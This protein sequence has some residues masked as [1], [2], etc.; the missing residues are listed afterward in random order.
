MAARSESQPN[1][2]PILL[3]NINKPLNNR[4]IPIKLTKSRVVV[5]LTG[6]SGIA[7]NPINKE[8]SK[9]GIKNKKMACQDRED[10]KIPPYVGPMAGAIEVVNV[11]TPIIVPRFS[12]GVK[13]KII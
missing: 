7:D 1:N 11:P 8:S 5:F 13:F 4:A 2:V 3:K 9:T 6:I 12:S 10:V